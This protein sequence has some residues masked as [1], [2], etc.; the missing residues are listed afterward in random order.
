MERLSEAEWKIL[1]VCW[2]LN[3]ASAQDVLA[4]LRQTKSVGLRT[5]QA[6]LARIATK[7]YLDVDTSMARHYF[8]PMVSREK[9][10]RSATRQFL[11]DVIGP[12]REGLEIV[13]REIESRGDFPSP[14]ASGVESEPA[15]PLEIFG[16]GARLLRAVRQSTAATLPSASREQFANDLEEALLTLSGVIHEFEPEAGQQTCAES[17]RLLARATGRLLLGAGIPPRKPALDWLE[18]IETELIPA[19]VKLEGWSYRRPV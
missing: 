2:R 7:G 1:H 4:E 14:P 8:E 9:A 13:A 6:Q 17:R 18:T 3:R 12:A 19:L 16:K 5:V 15:D 10:L 11:S